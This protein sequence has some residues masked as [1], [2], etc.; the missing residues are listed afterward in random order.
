[1]QSFTAR[2]IG[3]HGHHG[4]G[5]IPGRHL[6]LPQFR[7]DPMAHDDVGQADAVDMDQDLRQPVGQAVDAVN[8]ERRQAHEG[9]FQRRRPGSR[10]GRR[11]EVH[12]IVHLTNDNVDDPNISI[13]LDN[14]ILL[15]KECHNKI[16][17]R[18][19]GKRAYDFDS[20]GNLLK[21]D[22]K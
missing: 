10:Y 2:F 13:N 12:H 19:E 21:T 3:D 1:M 17:G 20:D 5:D 15:C 16:H 9:R 4:G 14:L 11:T 7:D 8:Q 22:N 6:V 18:F